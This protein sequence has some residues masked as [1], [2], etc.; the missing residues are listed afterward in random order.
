MKT[1]TTQTVRVY[2]ASQHTFLN[3]DAEFYGIVKDKNGKEW[4]KIRAKK[5]GAPIKLVHPESVVV[6]DVG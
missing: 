3:Y 1:K 5:Q 4:A 6:C 2:P